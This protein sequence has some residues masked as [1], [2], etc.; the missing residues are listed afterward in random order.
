[1]GRQF[2]ERLSPKTETQT[3]TRLKL[4]SD[5]YM[6]SL[7]KCHTESVVRGKTHRLVFEIV[8]TKQKPLLGGA[9]CTD[10]GLVKFTIPRE[11]LPAEVN[12]ID[13]SQSMP[14]T[15]EML[16]KDFHDVFHDPIESVPG[17]VH[18]DLNPEVTLVQCSP[19]NVPVAL[20]AWVKEELDKHVKAGNLT[21][22]TE[23]TAWISNMVT[24]AKPDKIRI[25]I[26][27]KPLNQALL[28]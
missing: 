19:R 9:A 2:K 24:V 17:N 15:K 4:Y 11:L 20:K 28:R 13:A 16:L 10:L 12:T 1:M 26:D 14:L 21:P 23:P 5:T 6:P 25:C 3:R 22:V 7:R 8:N 27:P 18:F